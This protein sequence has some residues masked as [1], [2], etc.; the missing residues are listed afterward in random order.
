[1][2]NHLLEER[3][4]WRESNSINKGCIRNRILVLQRRRKTVFDNI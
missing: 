3:F 2:L 4:P 1:M